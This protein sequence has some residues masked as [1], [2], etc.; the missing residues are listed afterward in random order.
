M[1]S[2]APT[3]ST[4]AR[5]NWETTSP[6]RNQP[7]RLLPLDSRPASCSPS[8]SLY[9]G[10]CSAGARPKSTPEA[11]AANKVKAS[12]LSIDPNALQKRKVERI[13]MRQPARASHGQ[14]QAQRGATTREGHALGEHLPQQPKTPGS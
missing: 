10:T 11:T 1:S 13:E 7:W 14:K 12:V 6:S 3:S 8:R 5:A 9:A 2:A 4:Q